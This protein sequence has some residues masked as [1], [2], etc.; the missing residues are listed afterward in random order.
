M[1]TKRRKM[2]AQITATRSRRSRSSAIAVGPFPVALA[3][4][5]P[6]GSAGPDPTVG[7]VPMGPDWSTS[8][9]T[10]VVTSIGHDT[11]T[12]VVRER[13]S[14]AAVGNVV[15]RRPVG[16]ELTHRM[17]N[18][19]VI[20]RYRARHKDVRDPHDELPHTRTNYHETLTLLGQ[21]SE[22]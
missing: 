8:G 17:N 15:A 16:N 1:R 12:C 14:D 22:S 21:S 6:A 2:L 7:R 20:T 10:R 3:A 19:S 18:S 9:S 4:A 13:H 5:V 11:S